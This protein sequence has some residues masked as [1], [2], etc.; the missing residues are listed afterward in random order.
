M[1]PASPALLQNHL[2]PWSSQWSPTCRAVARFAPTSEPPCFSV[3]NMAPCKR[4]SGSRE[5]SPGRYRALSA[6]SPKV[7]TSRAAP[8]VMQMGQ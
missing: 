1:T 2:S 7:A 6:S 3:R 4:V 5:V 8:S